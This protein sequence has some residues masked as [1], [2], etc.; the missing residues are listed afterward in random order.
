MLKCISQTV[1]VVVAP[2]LVN[3][4]LNLATVRI[5]F[6]ESAAVVAGINLAGCGHRYPLR[7]VFHFILKKKNTFGGMCQQPHSPHEWQG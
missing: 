7:F 2:G 6:Q 4:A 1:V 3:M 5:L